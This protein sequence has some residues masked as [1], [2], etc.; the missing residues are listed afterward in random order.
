MLFACHLALNEKMGKV[1]RALGGRTEEFCIPWMVDREDTGVY[2]EAFERMATV[3]GRDKAKLTYQLMG[4]AQETYRAL[5][6]Q[7]AR[8]YR[9]M[10]TAILY[11]HGE[12]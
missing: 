12:L 1:S 10:K 2:H 3:V 5:S 11:W 8:D 6:Q 9:N 4:K 7:E